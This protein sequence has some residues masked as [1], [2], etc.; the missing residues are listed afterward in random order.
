MQICEVIID[1]VLRSVSGGGN[2]RLL[3][4]FLE[5]LFSQLSLH[6]ERKN[7]RKVERNSH[8]IL[9]Y[10]WISRAD[11]QNKAIKLGI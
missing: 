5:P 11:M 8:L 4:F 2:V 3:I 10:M 6:C 7:R 1:V 9:C